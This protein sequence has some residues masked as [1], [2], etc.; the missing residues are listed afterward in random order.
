[1]DLHI[2][3]SFALIFLDDRDIIGYC[4]NSLSQCV[5]LGQLDGLI[6]TGLSDTRAVNVLQAYLDRTSDIQTVAL[7][8]S[9]MIEVHSTEGKDK[10]KQT[11]QT[12][13][14]E[15][16]MVVRLEQWISIYRSLL[17]Q[18]SM[19][20]VRAKFDIARSVTATRI[21]KAT[22]GSDKTLRKPARVTPKVVAR[23]LTCNTSYLLPGLSGNTGQSYVPRYRGGSSRVQTSARIHNC[24]N[25]SCKNSQLPRCAL[26]LNSLDLATP[27]KKTR[28]AGFARIRQKDKEKKQD[29]EREERKRKLK[30][31]LQENSNL[32][33]Y[34]FIYIYIYMC[35]CVWWMYMYIYVC[36][37]YFPRHK[38][39]RVCA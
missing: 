10:D 31:Q 6:M 8:S 3:L 12:A 17:N 7:L 34:V 11:A 30:I 39:R 2:R 19:F 25:P 9:F 26:C 21:H 13:Q 35:V 36:I 22:E 23:C 20:S 38:R 15:Q 28:F 24:P 1:V 5:S 37:V 27:V 14:Q 32:G 4:E 18:W 16:A 29:K 33:M